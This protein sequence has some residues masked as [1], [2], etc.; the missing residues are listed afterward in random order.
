MMRE[1]LPL[2]GHLE[3]GLPWDRPPLAEP[4]PAASAWL[5]V[6]VF[7]SA[8]LAQVSLFSDSPKPHRYLFER[9]DV[10][11]LGKYDIERLRPPEPRCLVQVIVQWEYIGCS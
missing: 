9:F 10:L 3:Q 6:G 11:R 7:C 4:D 8:S 2:F 5:V 1:S